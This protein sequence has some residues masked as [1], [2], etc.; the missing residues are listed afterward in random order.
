MMFF[1][2]RE[3][4][5]R[6]AGYISLVATDVKPI[7]PYYS[8]KWAKGIVR[9]LDDLRDPYAFDW[10]PNCFTRPP[11]DDEWWTVSPPPPN[12]MIW[13]SAA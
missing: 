10:Y 8:F 6:T 12:P 4:C 11:T 2:H 7:T 1:E 5:C 13:Y 9:T 3:G